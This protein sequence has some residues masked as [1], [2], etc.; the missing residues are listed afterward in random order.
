MLLGQTRVSYSM[1]RDGL[2]PKGLGAVHPKFGTPYVVTIAIGVLCCLLAAF[3]PVGLLATLVNIGTLLAFVVVSA[4]VWVLR[5]RQ[6]DLPRPFRT[7]LV[8]LVPILGI[9]FCFGLILTL[10]SSTWLRLVI[11]TIIGF[12]IY[13]GYGKSH[14]R[15]A[16]AAGRGPTSAAAD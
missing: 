8:P 13:F 4:G 1:A 15:A 2:I 5:V 12:A 7:P 10:P 11:W 9:V 6:P 3:F 14:S 16:A